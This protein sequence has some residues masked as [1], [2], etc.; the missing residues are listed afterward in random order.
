MGG[1]G[2]FFTENSGYGG[3]MDPAERGGV[4]WVS[5]FCPVKGSSWLPHG[6]NASPVLFKKSTRWMTKR[7]WPVSERYRISLPT[8]SST[9]PDKTCVSS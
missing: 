4:E 7:E 9:L 2:E 1:Y 3:I 5:E 8:R 6:F